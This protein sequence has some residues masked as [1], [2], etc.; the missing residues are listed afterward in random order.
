MNNEYEDLMQDE[1]FR[2][3]FAMESLAAEASELI[4]RLMA[5]QNLSKADLA[6]KLGKTRSWITQLLSGKTNM[7]VCTLA[8]IANALNAEVKLQAQPVNWK[9][10]VLPSDL[11]T[12]RESARVIRFNGTKAQ[13]SETV[14][15]NE[16]PKRP[17]YAA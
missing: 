17:S 8:E 11:Y 10:A 16:F 4:A 3:L 2:R 13:E 12:I 15:S 5:E 7:T 1:K 9:G 14:D 6:R